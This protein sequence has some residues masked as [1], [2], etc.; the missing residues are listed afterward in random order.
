MENQNHYQLQTQ[1]AQPAQEI[2]TAGT[3]EILTRLRRNLPTKGG[4]IGDKKQLLTVEK[5]CDLVVNF[6]T[7]DL[8]SQISD[9]LSGK[10]ISKEI[11]LLIL[12]AAR[13]LN[14]KRI[15][16]ENDLFEIVDF[17]LEDY[18]DLTFE[19]LVLFF[20]DVKKQKYGELYENFSGGKILMYLKTYSDYK[21][22]EMS[23]ARKRQVEN[24]DKEIDKTLPVLTKEQSDKISKEIRQL[25]CAIASDKKEKL[26]ISEPAPFQIY[27]DLWNRRDML[28]SELNVSKPEYKKSI[29][30]QLTAIDSQLDKLEAV[31]PEFLDTEY[32]NRQYL[33]YFP[34]SQPAAVPEGCSLPSDAQKLVK[35]I[36]PKTIL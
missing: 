32:Y 34:N 12:S 21:E 33:K 1:H 23:K 7:S 10:V 11:N 30:L 6:E 13:F 4:E 31:F 9:K 18:G 16:D 17:I 14:V 36:K 26:K 2:I 19:E 20:N 8:N 35:T 27:I 29:V 25:T 22:S 24:R 15:P 5:I 3:N 28:E